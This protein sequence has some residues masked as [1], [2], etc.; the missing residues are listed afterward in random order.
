M[1]VEYESDP[2]LDLTIATIKGTPTLDEILSAVESFYSNQPT[3]KVIWDW[4]ESDPSRLTAFDV[5]LLA[6]FP[7]RYTD[8]REGG[9]TAMVAPDNLSFGISR[10][11]Q[12]FGQMNGLPFTV[13]VFHSIGDAFLWIADTHD[14]P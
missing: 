11:F 1:P 13:R 4:T 12:T 9:K 2:Y 3:K 6:G 10:M 7:A 8:L 14:K 5:E